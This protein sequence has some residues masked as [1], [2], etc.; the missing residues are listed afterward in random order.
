Q[1]KPRCV[2]TAT[3]V[4]ALGSNTAGG[5]GNSTS[6]FCGK[7][8][9]ASGM[10]DPGASCPNRAGRGSF[11]PPPPLP[12][13]PGCPVELVSAGR[14]YF[15]TPRVTSIPTRG[16]KGVGWRVVAISASTVQHKATWKTADN[17]WAFPVRAERSIQQK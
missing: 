15:S 11:S 9:G 8:G 4:G 1:G 10:E 2:T 5:T 17:A 3:F 12:L 14:K 7:R 6:R 13:R 16:A